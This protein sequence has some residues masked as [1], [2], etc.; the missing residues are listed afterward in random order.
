MA[1]ALHVINDFTFENAFG[2]NVDLRYS[3]QVII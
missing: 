2:Q 3:I 1:Y